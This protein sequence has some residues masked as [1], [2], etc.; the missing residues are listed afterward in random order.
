MESP[1]SPDVP[2]G[3]FRTD[4]EAVLFGF[5]PAPVAVTLRPRSRGWRMAGAVRTM[6][7]SMVVAPMVA[8]VPPHAPWVIGALTVGGILAR[9]RWTEHFTLLE[10]EGRCPR[11]GEELH[12]KAGRLR[13][14]HPLTCEECHHAST[15]QL[16]SDALAESA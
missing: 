9:R 3:S 8:V 7:I 5:P 11:C 6:A 2:E 15:L 14:P 4:A 13:R 12:V 1:T 16:P 10:L